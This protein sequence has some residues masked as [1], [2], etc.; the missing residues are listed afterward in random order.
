MNTNILV[1]YDEVNAI[2]KDGALEVLE[3][4]TLVRFYSSYYYYKSQ[5]TSLRNRIEL[6]DLADEIF[7]KLLEKDYYAKFNNKI[8][9]KKYFI[10][11]AVYR[12]I[13]DLAVR[14]RDDKFTSIKNSVSIDA[15]DEDG[16]SLSM[17]LPDHFS[18]EKETESKY[19]YEQII[20][21]IPCDILKGT[22][23]LRSLALALE[24]GLSTNEISKEFSLEITEVYQLKSKLRNYILDNIVLF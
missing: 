19:S 4:Y 3:G 2:P 17:I 22:I 13:L 5:F 18:V 11:I 6:E 23:S 20:E 14:S 7:T 10:Q 8:T 1:S 15:E 21:K 24:E 12:A 16:F 9:T